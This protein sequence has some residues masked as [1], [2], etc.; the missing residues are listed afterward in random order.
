MKTEY[1]I[2]KH[3]FRDDDTGAVKSYYCIEVLKLVWGLKS[4]IHM[5]RYLEWQIYTHNP[6]AG[7]F[8]TGAK[9]DTL[10]RAKK[11][12]RNLRQPVHLPEQV[13]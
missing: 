8:R 5:G 2:I 12:L 1:R 4:L 9:F 3:C 13:K 7:M 11:Y 10:K 6:M